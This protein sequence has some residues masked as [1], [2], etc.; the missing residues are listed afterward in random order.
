MDKL[1]ANIAIMLRAGCNQDNFT[2][3]QLWQTYVK[4]SKFNMFS[5][6]KKYFAGKELNIKNTMYN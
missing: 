2:F 3:L 4:Q 1:K 5:D 6:L